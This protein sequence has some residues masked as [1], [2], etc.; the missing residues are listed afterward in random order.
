[1]SCSNCKLFHNI[2]KAECCTLPPIEQII[3]NRNFDKIL[4]PVIK[5]M[6]IG[7]GVIV[8]I[9]DGGKCPFLQEDLGCAIYHDKPSICEKFGDESHVQMTCAYQTKDGEARTKKESRKIQDLHK[10]ASDKSL[11]R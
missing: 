9:T 10:K 8:P 6:P 7:P 2:C 5:V 1:M 4:R 3:F 11:G